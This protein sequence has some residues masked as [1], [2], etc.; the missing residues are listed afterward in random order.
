MTAEQG[1]RLGLT[2]RD[3]DVTAVGS[4]DRIRNMNRM[5]HARRPSLD[6]H[7]ARVFTEHFKQTEGESYLKRRYEALAKVYETMPVVIYDYERLIGWQGSRIRSSSLFP[8]VQS[9]WLAED[10]NTLATRDYDPWQST[11]EQ[12]EELL[13]DIIPYW[14]E[15]TLH[16]KWAKQTPN[17]ELASSGYLDCTNMPGNPGAHFQADMEG[18]FDRGIKGIYEQCR[19][20]QEEQDYSLPE[21]L[22]KREFY[23]GMMKVCQGI[24]R[25][26]ENMKKAAYTKAADTDDETRAEELK[27][28]G[29]R[30]AKICWEKPETFVECLH[31]MWLVTIFV[32]T[33]SPAP[34]PCGLGRVD[35]YLWPYLERDLQ[36]GKMTIDEAY[37]YLQEFCVKCTN[38]VWLMPKNLTI[39]FGGYYR[40]AGSYAVGGVDERGQDAVN[41]LSYL[42]LR[43]SRV[44][45]TTAPPVHVNIS[46]KNPDSFL[47]EAVKLCAAGTG[48]PAFFDVDTMHNTLRNKSAGNDSTNTWPMEELRKYGCS[49][50]CQESGLM[51]YAY[52]HS[53]ACIVNLGTCV[54]LALNNGVRPEKCPGYGAGEKIGVETGAAAGF[55]SFEDVYQAVIKQFKHAVDVGAE[56]VLICEKLQREEYFMPMQSM[57]AKDCIETGTDIVQ[58]ARINQGPCFTVIGVA[59]FADSLAAVKKLVFEDKTVTMGQ[60]LDAIETDFEGY[61]DIRKLC[62]DAPKWGNDDD[63]VDQLLADAVPELTSYVR[64]KRNTRG[65]YLDLSV[66]N[67][68]VQVPAGAQCW[69]LPSGRKAFTPFADTLSAEQHMD[70]NGPLSAINSYAKIDHAAFSNGTILNMWIAKSELIEEQQSDF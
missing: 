31:L 6:L 64:S 11:E 23:S 38:V 45:R 63:Y 47:H 4:T 25:Y 12:R 40:W 28:A 10:L 69:A 29:E 17:A 58:N 39:L 68:Q 14:K 16:Y 15:K 50:G 18:L 5:L 1:G 60:L 7:R 61:D 41:P 52:G 21:N 65:G 53:N 19:A 37:E 3:A 57:V 22:G 32:M 56:H 43:A 33:E 51:G 36:E 62:L 59:D 55:R 2:L 8:E 24:R 20:F 46:A 35:Q 54:S 66:Q 67:N 30:I 9:H 70:V 34:A 49:F 48:Q 42:F 27:E 44:T 26:G 13:R